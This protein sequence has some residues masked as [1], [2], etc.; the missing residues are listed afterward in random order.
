MAAF[1]RPAL[2]ETPEEF[3]KKNNVE[4]V[5]GFSAGGGTDSAAR[6]VTAYWSDTFGGLAKINNMP[7]GGTVVATNYVWRAKPDGLT[8][9]ITPFGT[10]LAATTLFGAPGMKFDVSKFSYIAMFAD[11]PPG[12]SIGKDLPYNSLEDLKKAK[13][14]KLGS[15]SAKGMPPF[16]G[17]TMLHLLGLDDGNVITGYDSAP[18][19]GLAIKRGEI[20]GM[21]FTSNSTD[22]EVKKGVTKALATVAYVGSPLL[23]G[24]KPVSE[25]L[26][27]SP[28]QQRILK[29]YDAAF[30][31]GRVLLGPPGMDPA[32][33][34][35]L[36]KKIVE[37]FKSKGY[38]AMAKTVFGYWEDPVVGKDL[39]K[40]IQEL[41]AMPK[42]DVDLMN[43]LAKKYIK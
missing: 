34:E 35:Y 19:V 25:L 2:S 29:V 32:K 5:V 27:L 23:P 40:L 8:L 21:V 22:K 16:G 4:I 3:F 12:F 15:T 14:L 13:G 17:V 38:Q 10:S 31:S 42:A 7:G 1:T 30:K 43:R 33:V 41:Q 39:E 9:L 37:L 6:T 24:V 20:H 26:K 18:E 36:R 11:E 28:E